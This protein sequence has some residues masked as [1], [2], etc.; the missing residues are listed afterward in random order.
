[1]DFKDNQEEAAYRAQV[2][3][4][5]GRHAPAFQLTPGDALPESEFMRRARAWQACKADAGYVGIHWPKAVGGQGAAPIRHVLFHQEEEHYAL[6]VV[7]FHVGLGMCLP[8]IFTHGAAE[9]AAR[10]VK[11]GMRGEE[12][13]CQL[14]SEPAAGSDLAGVRTRAVRDGEDWVVN[15]QK[16]WT[17][18]A[19]EAQ[20]GIVLT[21]TDPDLPKHKG[22]TMFFIDMRSPGVDV[23][24]IRTL[25]GDAE[26]NEVFLTDVRI[27]DSQRLGAVGEGWKV[28]L[29]TLMFERFAVGG[30]P[31]QAPGVNDLLAL[32]ATLVGEGGQVLDIPGL[33]DALSRFYVTD[34]GV[35]LT[36]L[37]AM[38]A[39]SRGDVPGPEASIGKLVMAKSL[40]DM[41]AFALELLGPAAIANGTA[42]PAHRFNYWYL[43][44]AGLRIAGGTDEILRNII[45]ER[46]LGLPPDIRVDRDLPFNQIGVG[47]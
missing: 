46:V 35:A 12:L 9:V 2:R 7:P 33:S 5:L 14:F 29:T 3:A 15:G 31:A 39:V 47:P 24:P 22:L 41:S 13:W 30:K 44:S 19:H 20:F 17:S 45:A 42:A 21:R 1:M 37:R 16:V 27:P 4:W 36:R 38:T 40:Q 6:P 28:S 10:Y 32:A 34:Q 11:P 8:T 26:F 23:R 25:L 18:Y 43:W